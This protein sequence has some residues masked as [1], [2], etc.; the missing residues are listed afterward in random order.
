VLAR[1]CGMS[2]V[3]YMSG[4]NLDIQWVVAPR[5]TR[6]VGR[7]GVYHG[8]GFLG[9]AGWTRM[10]ALK[11]PPEKM[12]NTEESATM[13]GSGLALV[14]SRSASAEGTAGFSL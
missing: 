6:P 13:E 8:A 10:N 5:D 9:P 2:G 1:A 14:W 4:L 12:S 3:G 7:D 11:Q